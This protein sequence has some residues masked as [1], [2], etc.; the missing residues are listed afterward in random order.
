M[1]KRLFGIIL[2]VIFI[3]GICT[4]VSAEESDKDHA[5]SL[6]LDYSINEKEFSG[7]E[8]KI[9][10]VAELTQEGEYKLIPPFSDYPINIHGITSQQQW[11]QTAQTVRNLV[12]GNNVEAYSSEFTDDDGNAYHKELETGLY[13]V[14]GIIVEEDKDGYIFN[15]FMVYLPTP[16]DDGYDYDI[17]AKPKCSLYTIPEKYTLVKLWNDGDDSSVRPQEVKVEIFRDGII[18]DSVILNSA[19]NWSY[20]WEVTDGGVWSVMETGVSEGYKVSIVNNN[21]SFV[22][23]NTYIPDV[24]DRPG[25]PD[26]PATGETSSVIVYALIFMISGFGLVILGILRMRYADENNR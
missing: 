4:G 15:D 10:R 7:L 12:M 25:D 1:M 8:T 5:C 11:Q 3:T 16:G 19:N 14:M 6:T 17:T 23:T 18:H 20:S 2:A 26:A 22:I 21:T 24:P 9:Y 13:M